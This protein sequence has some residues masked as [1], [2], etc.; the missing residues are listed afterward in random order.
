MFKFK[1]DFKIVPWFMYDQCCIK[2]KYHF[3]YINSSRVSCMVLLRYPPSHSQ[4]AWAPDLHA[5]RFRPTLSLSV[6]CPDHLDKL[7]PA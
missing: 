4:I 5:A 3:W 2:L 7:N 6:S 1:E